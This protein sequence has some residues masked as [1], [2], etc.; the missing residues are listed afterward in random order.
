M[1]RLLSA[2]RFSS[3]LT[4]FASKG[5]KRT[6][7]Q[8][9]HACTKRFQLLSVALSRATLTTHSELSSG[10]ADT[11]SLDDMQAHARTRDDAPSQND[12]INLFAITFDKDQGQV[13]GQ[14]D[15]RP[16]S[17]QMPLLQE[18]KVLNEKA[19]KSKENAPM[20]LCARG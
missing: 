12:Q 7:H 20:H 17:A 6:R 11:H 19:R 15:E 10:Q 14:A 4:H 2:R 8:V 1:I 3:S 18:K 13:K 9:A 5:K 16:I